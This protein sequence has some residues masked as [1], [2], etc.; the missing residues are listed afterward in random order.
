MKQ[1]HKLNDLVT[2][3]E[4]YDVLIR[5]RIGIENTVFQLR[6]ELIRHSKILLEKEKKSHR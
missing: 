4:K 1:V 5:R 3:D 6:S 2:D